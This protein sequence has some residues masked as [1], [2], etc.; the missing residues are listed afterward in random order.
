MTERPDCSIQR[1][2]SIVERLRTPDG[3]PWDQAQTIDSLKPFL[4]EECHEFLGAIDRATTDDIKDELGD[5]LL[6]VVLYARIFEEQNIFTLHDAA[7][8]ICNK[9]VRRHP[10]V[11]NPQPENSNPDLNLQWEEIKQSEKAG[12]G[13]TPGL[14]EQL[15]ADLPPLLAA[16]KIS[17][18]AAR[19]G[20]DWPDS[21]SVLLKIREELDELE[22]AIDDNDEDA[23]NHELGDLLFSVVNIARHLNVDT[24]LSLRQNNARFISR[25]QFMESTLQTQ[26]RT[27][28]DCTISEMDQLWERAKHHE[29]NKKRA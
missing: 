19:V 18:K 24:E 26:N 4:L 21:K 15:D 9:L 23:I 1:L 28:S 3:C 6:Q 7:E 2:I 10:H 13:I 20:M 12:P 16:H 27:F 25:I 17:K 14:F 29:E 11:F 5:L 8:S 22:K